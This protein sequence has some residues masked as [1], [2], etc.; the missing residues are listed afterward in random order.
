LDGGGLTENDEDFDSGEAN[1][2]GIT[3]DEESKVPIEEFTDVEAEGSAVLAIK[4][5]T[6]EEEEGGGNKVETIDDSA[7]A[8]EEEEYG[9]AANDKG[10]TA[11]EAAGR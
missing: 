4:V 8:A 11:E 5:G 1:V 6:D 2:A 10:E 3:I 9:T 7:G